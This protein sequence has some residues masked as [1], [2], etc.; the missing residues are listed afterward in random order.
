MSELT[1]NEYRQPVLDPLFDAMFRPQPQREPPEVLP[2]TAAPEAAAKPASKP[3][4]RP[5]KDHPPSGSG[6]A[7]DTAGALL[8]APA[9]ESAA[10]ILSIDDARAALSKLMDAKGMPACTAVL[11]EFGATRISAVPPEKYGELVAAAEKAARD[12]YE[13]AQ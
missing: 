2:P 13:E 7:V 9:D 12:E 11:E 6:P 1:M 8:V 5:R 4:G 3:R 10:G